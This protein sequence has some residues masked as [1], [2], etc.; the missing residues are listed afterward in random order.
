MPLVTENLVTQLGGRQEG[1]LIRSADWNTLVAAVAAVEKTI[2]DRLDAFE[3]KVAEEFAAVG[4]RV[5]LLEKRVEERFLKTDQRL[6]ELEKRE[7][8]RFERVSARLD[9]V[10]GDLWGAGKRLDALTDR[11]TNAE[12]ATQALGAKVKPVVDAAYVVTLRTKDVAYSMGELADV[13]ARISYLPGAPPQSLAGK[14]VD[15]VTSWGTFRAVD[16]FL[17]RGGAGDRTMSVMTDEKGIARVLLHSDIADE[18]PVEAAQEVTAALR[19]KLGTK[20][21]VSEV[22]LSANTPEDEDV[23]AAYATVSAKYD[24]EDSSLRSYVDAYYLKNQAQIGI[25]D[26][27]RALPYWRQRWRDYNATILAFAKDDSDPTTPDASRG[28]GSIQVTFRDWLRPWLVIDY[29]TRVEEVS[30]RMVEHFIPKVGVTLEGSVERMRTQVGELVKNR[31]VVGKLRDY[32]AMDVAFDKL[33]VAGREFVPDLAKSM[34]AA[35]GL[36]KSIESNT[37]SM[38]GDASQELVFKALTRSSVPTRDDRVDE[39]GVTLDNVNVQ[40][41]EQIEERFGQVGATVDARLKPTMD[42]IPILVAERVNT[43]VPQLME[44]RLTTFGT[45]YDARVESLVTGKLATFDTTVTSRINSASQTLNT[46]IGSLETTIS[47][48]LNTVES[49]LTTYSTR[50]TNVERYAG[51]FETSIKSMESEVQELSGGMRTLSKTVETIPRLEEQMLVVSKETLDMRRKIGSMEGSMESFSKVD[52][53]E[54]QN[55]VSAVEMMNSS[56]LSSLK[57]G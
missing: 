52:A 22:F 24:R 47:S 54:L 15:F 29:W 10:A 36:Q 37:A 35:V 49:S 2:V 9:E 32:D 42:T 43:A 1:G 7:Q 4:Q 46:R 18:M 45:T 33:N 38:L 41:T 34:R 21:T 25:Q 27:R 19:T 16:G 6:D 56:L 8:E 53:T 39:L 13:E 50:L 20:K 51:G 40:L 11:A 30:D 28:T 12:H 48:R 57:V 14:W 55:R 31:G 23:K 44:T 5:D 3:Q 17:T 26:P